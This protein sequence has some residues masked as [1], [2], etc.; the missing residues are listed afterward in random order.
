MHPEPAPVS[1]ATSCSERMGQRPQ[2]S[3]SSDWETCKQRQTTST[4]S[5]RTTIGRES[6]GGRTELVSA[7]TESQ[8]TTFYQLLRSVSTKS[9]A[10]LLSQGGRK[11]GEP[12]KVERRPERA[13]PAGLLSPLHSTFFSLV[14]ASDSTSS[15]P[16]RPSQLWPGS[17]PNSG[18]L[19][20]QPCASRGSRSR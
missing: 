18:R 15:I 20:R 16:A 1:R 5:R 3:S 13:A 6:T 11:R 4:S 17:A 14:R 19:C 2:A 8:L 7:D 12:E 10:K 9:L